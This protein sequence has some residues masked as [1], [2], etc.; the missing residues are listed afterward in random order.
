[1]RSSHIFSPHS[2][3]L[4][5]LIQ[6]P[7]IGCF[8]ASCVATFPGI[9][10]L[11]HATPPFVGLPSIKCIS[12]KMA[13]SILVDHASALEWQIPSSVSGI[14]QTT[15]IRS[16]MK[17]CWRTSIICISR[18]E[19]SVKNAGE[20]PSV[21]SSAQHSMSMILRRSPT[22]ARLSVNSRITLIRG[23]GEYYSK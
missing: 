4:S 7:A 13:H 8:W 14:S 17:R 9:S 18:I 1:M 21:I 23:K 6:R 10:L 15:L 2:L 12:N 3:N 20:K 11:S 5:L 22:N 16:H 19:V